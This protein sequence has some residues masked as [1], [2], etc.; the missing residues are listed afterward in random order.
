MSKR[1]DYFKKRVK[2]LGMLDKDSDYD[3][4]IGKSVI[5]LS[6]VFSKQGH[7]GCSADVT[8]QLFNKLMKEWESPLTHKEK[9]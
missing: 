4:M 3:G 6:S 7:S 1:H 8:C 5:Q 2:E 9:L